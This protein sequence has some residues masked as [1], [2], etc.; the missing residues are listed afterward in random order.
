MGDHRWR[1][2]I[3]VAILAGLFLGA[4]QI[5]VPGDFG[6]HE[7]GYMYGWHRKGNE[8]EWKGVTVKYR[9]R[10]YCRPCHQRNYDSILPSP[11]GGI[12]CENCHGPALDHPRDPRTMRIDRSRAL[13][14]RCH[15]RLPYGNGGRGA[16]RGI[17]PVTHN[18]EEECTLCHYP[19]DPRKG[20]DQ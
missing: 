4:R 7:R 6:V 8:A 20:G 1:P 15:C 3:G 2:L 10:E 17:D 16:I 18:P 9:G 19:H 13:C 12:G 14:I 11:H 5:M